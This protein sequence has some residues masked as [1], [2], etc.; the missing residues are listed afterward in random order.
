VSCSAEYKGYDTIEFKDST[1]IIQDSIKVMNRLLNKMSNKKFF[2]MYFVQQ[3]GRVLITITDST[4]IIVS[5]DD[6][7]YTSHT[8]FDKLSRKEKNQMLRVAQYLN[9][10]YLSGAIYDIYNSDTYFYYYHYWENNHDAVT[11]RYITLLSDNKLSAT[12]IA[13]K[14]SYRLIESKQSLALYSVR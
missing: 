7:V 12:Q 3:D 14:S 13:D 11:R 10:N 1:S 6:T 9:A 4:E 2:P 8:I 5:I